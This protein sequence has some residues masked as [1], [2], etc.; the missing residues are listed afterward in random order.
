MFLTVPYDHGDGYGCSLQVFLSLTLRCSLQVFL[1]L[2][3]RCGLQ[4]FLSLT[5]SVTMTIIIIPHV[6]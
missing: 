6:L 2:T 4:V 1:S 5:L 3:L